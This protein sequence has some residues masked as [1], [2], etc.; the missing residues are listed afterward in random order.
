MADLAQLEKEVKE[1]RKER[2]EEKRQREE[3]EKQREEAEK[4]REEAEKQ[5]EEAEKQ[6][7]E[8]EK[9]RE[10]AEKQ[11][12]EAEKQREKVEKELDLVKKE[13]FKAH[14]LTHAPSSCK[15]A[16]EAH[17]GIPTPPLSH[18]FFHHVKERIQVHVLFF[19]LWRGS[20][21]KDQTSA[22]HFFT[23]PFGKR[24]PGKESC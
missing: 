6:R 8:A 21:E 15:G 23:A 14:A 20:M 9:Q 10:E 16:E 1:L 19:H 4:Q 5:R 2:D 13:K 17:V 7:E 18:W 24:I 11:R 12:E 22:S 3:A